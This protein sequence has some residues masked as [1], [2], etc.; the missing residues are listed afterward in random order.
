MESNVGDTNPKPGDQ[1]SNRRQ[2][3]EPAEDLARSI[4]DGC[5][6]LQDTLF[7]SEDE[8]D[9]TYPCMRIDQTRSK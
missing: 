4:C 6:R 1:A 7:D 9:R 3:D 2:V 8:I 5:G